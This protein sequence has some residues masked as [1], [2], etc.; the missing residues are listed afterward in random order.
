MTKEPIQA[1][2]K[3]LR[4]NVGKPDYHLFDPVALEA[5]S[6]V[7]AYGAK[8]YAP[9]NWERGMKWTIMFNSLL[10]HSWAWL[11]GEE[12]DPESGCLHMA[13]VAWNALGL[14]SYHLRKLGE[15]D[16]NPTVDT[17][18]QNHF[19]ATQTGFTIGES[20]GSAQHTVADLIKEGQRL[21][22]LN[23]PAPPPL[24]MDSFGF[25]LGSAV[26]NMSLSDPTA[27]NGEFPAPSATP[28]PIMAIDLAKVEGKMAA[29]LADTMPLH[30]RG[31]D[32]GTIRTHT[33]RTGRTFQVGE[34]V[35]L[36]GDERLWVIQSIRG[37]DKPGESFVEFGLSQS[38][39]A[40]CRALYVTADKIMGL[41]K[42]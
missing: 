23:E 24:R 6:N 40:D 16:R 14:C 36:N 35:R 5:L 33:D 42:R 20:N 10:R 1:D 18:N 2:G 29:Y 22:I 19:I 39:V 17:A 34:E 27:D 9:R 7:F 30:Q 11:R 25:P 3:G 15:D 31:F 4:F 21:G 8:K 12:Y 41:R 32:K 28:N 38:G 26:Q 13:H 37:E